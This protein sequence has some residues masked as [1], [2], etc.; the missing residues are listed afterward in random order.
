MAGLKFALGLIPNTAK[1]EEKDKKLRKEYQQY[2]E[3]EN[4]EELKRLL[5]L[6]KEVN[7]QGFAAKKKEILSRKYKGT[8]EYAKEKEFKRLEKSKPIRNYFQVKD[9]KALEEYKSF[10]DSDLKKRIEELEAFVKSDAVAKAKANLSPKEY[11]S[12]EEAAKEKEYIQ[13]IKSPRTKKN[14]KFESSN[15]YREYKRIEESDTLKR[16]KELKEYINTEKFKEV[17]DYMNLPGKKKYILSDEYK[18]ETEYIELKDSDKIQWYFKTKKKYPFAE[19][20]KWDLVMEESFESA[21]PD[22]KKWIHRYLSAEKL[23]GKPYVLADDLHAFTDGKNIEIISNHLSIVTKPEKA[24]SFTWSPLTGFTEKEFDYTSDILASSKDVNFKYGLFKAKVKIGSSGVT[25]AFS[26]MAGQMLPHIDVFR[27]DRN[28][29]SAGSFWKNGSKEGISKSVDKTGG[30]RY[31][32]DFFI[33][34]LEWEPGKM[35]WKINDVPFKVQTQNIPESNMHLVFNSSLK[36]HSKI[37]GLPS[38]ME[39]D[40]IRV[41]TAKPGEEK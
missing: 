22:P 25:Q 31:T 1:V 11:K 23:L 4:S 14:K 9:S 2:K 26:L 35:T 37:M 7:S 17:K 16:F 8:E 39:I 30:S 3:I 34:S 10:L 15:A 12:S 33:Y 40:W 18:K 20:E 6:E 28:K 38:K 32:R 36:K 21:A 24:K 27:Y 19:V 5:E 13:L 29:L 41:Y